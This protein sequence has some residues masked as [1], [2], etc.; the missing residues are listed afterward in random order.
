MGISC[1]AA[2]IVH[3]YSIQKFELLYHK[4]VNFRKLFFQAVYVEFINSGSCHSKIGRAYWPFPVSQSI[5]IGKCAHLVILL[6]IKTKKLLHFIKLHL[7]RFFSKRSRL[8][9][10]KCNLLLRLDTS[11]MR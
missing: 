6:H 11:N 9:T 10:Q 7:I 8:L 5:Y 2:M 4:N 3:F 1:Q